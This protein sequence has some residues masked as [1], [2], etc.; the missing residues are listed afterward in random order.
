MTDFIENMFYDKHGSYFMVLASV[1]PHSVTNSTFTL[2]HFLN[3]NADQTGQDCG[4][5]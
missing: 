2:N 4:C 3:N 1:S 5:G